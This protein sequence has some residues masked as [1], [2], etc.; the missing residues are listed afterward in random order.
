MRAKPLSA[1]SRCTIWFKQVFDVLVGVLGEVGEEEI[2]SFKLLHAM[3]GKG[4]EIKPR[5]QHFDFFLDRPLQPEAESIH[6]LFFK[7]LNFVEATESDFE[8]RFAAI[9][10]DEMVAVILE[11]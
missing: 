2:A 8:Q 5:L 7:V 3:R 6:S 1:S 10:K 9:E 4:G 11:G